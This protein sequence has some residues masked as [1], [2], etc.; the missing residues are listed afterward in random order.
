MV[1]PGRRHG[2]R[3]PSAGRFK[4]R[5]T[6]LPGRGHLDELDGTV[7]DLLR[8]VFSSMP[9][10]GGLPVE[11]GARPSRTV[12]C[13]SKSRRR[14]GHGRPALLLACPATIIPGYL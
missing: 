13:R 2:P 10:V 14:Y 6:A 4:M 3:L 8:G 7:A 9:A 11:S 12:R 5:L 1:L